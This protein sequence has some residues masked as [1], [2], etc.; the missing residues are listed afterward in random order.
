VSSPA[1]LDHLAA[2]TDPVRCRVL[3]LLEQEE[4]MV[5]ELCTALQLPQSTVS[6]HLKLLGDEGWIAGRA[7]GTSRWYRL[8]ADSMGEGAAQ[9]WAVVRGDVAAS[10]EA[11]EDSRRLKSVLSRRRTRSQE[12]FDSTAGRW[13]DV[14]AQLFGDRADLPALLA[15]LDDRWTVGDLGCGTGRIAGQV[16][17]FVTKVIAVDESE[18]MLGAARTR[19]LGQENVDLRQGSLQQLPVQDGE[20]DAALLFLVLH[21]V[22]DPAKAVREAAR[23]LKPGGK[24]MLVEM[25]PHGRT[26]YQQTMGHRWLGFE[27]STVRSWFEGAGLVRPRFAPLSPDVAAKGPTLFVATAHAP[28]DDR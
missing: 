16:A 5:A 15:L 17:P 11:R 2:L 25:R 23:A 22:A 24:V 27:E 10:A 4:L 14:R 1:L 26:E 9:L 21:Y 7:E 28:Q 19:M 3:L 6:R 20:L 18:A 13:D 8:A 12:F